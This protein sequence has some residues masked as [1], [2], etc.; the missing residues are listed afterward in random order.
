MENAKMITDKDHETEAALMTSNISNLEKQLAGREASL[1]ELEKVGQKA[2]L[3]VFE[4]QMLFT[5]PAKFMLACS[6][7]KK[8]RQSQTTRSA[9]SKKSSILVRW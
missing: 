9:S 1:R 5:Y 6:L 2:F 4:A 7:T 8:L 3:D